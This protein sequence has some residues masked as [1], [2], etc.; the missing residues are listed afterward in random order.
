MEAL[1]DPYVPSRSVRATGNCRLAVSFGKNEALA[2]LLGMLRNQDFLVFP[3]CLPLL[4]SVSFCCI[5]KI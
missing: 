3:P 4:I 5:K 2:P 1:G